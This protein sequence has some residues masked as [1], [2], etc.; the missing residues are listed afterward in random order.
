[1]RSYR[2]R[3]GRVQSS[4]SGVHEARETEP[5]AFQDLV[6]LGLSGDGGNP[7]IG[8]SNLP[9]GLHRKVCNPHPVRSAT[10]TRWNTLV[11][12]EVFVAAGPT[13]KLH[14]EALAHKVG[15][16][17][18]RQGF[19]H[20]DVYVGGGVNIRKAASDV[21]GCSK[22]HSSEAYQAQRHARPW[23]PCTR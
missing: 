13:R 8:V 17:C 15:T 9:A 21:S 6:C 4:S 1:M 23:R 12:G 16:I 3:L 2:S 11:G 5:W 19:A 22:A 14:D 7:R 10:R 20:R 18:T